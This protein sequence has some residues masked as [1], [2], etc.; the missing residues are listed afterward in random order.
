MQNESTKVD[1]TNTPH[2]VI[3]LVNENDEVIGEVTKGEANSNPSLI[4]RE[5]AILLFNNEK[6]ILLQ[7]R[8][9]LKQVNPLKWAESVAGHIPKGMKVEDAAYME[10]KEEIG[11]NVPLTFVEK[12]L[13]H[14]KNETHFTYWF[15]GKYNG[16]ECTLEP[17]EVEQVKLFSKEDI[18]QMEKDG[19]PLVSVLV[20]MAHRY[21]D[22]EFDHLIK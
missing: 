4:H 6:K 21:W 1:K 11:L 7:Q 19:T 8:S 17:A 3:D 15:I 5:I 9:R 10:L 22:G 2:E 13:D 18:A 14:S 12:Q 20:K 16:E